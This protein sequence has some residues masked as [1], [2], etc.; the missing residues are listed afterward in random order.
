MKNICPVGKASIL[1][2]MLK[3]QAERRA[4]VWRKHLNYYSKI[5]FKGLK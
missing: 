5:F 1:I 2:K 4:T 3:Q